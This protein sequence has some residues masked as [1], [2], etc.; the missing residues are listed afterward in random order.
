MIINRR[1]LECGTPISA[2]RSIRA[3]FCPGRSCL[4]KFNMRRWSSNNRDRVNEHGR[5]SS[6]RRRA[7]LAA[8]VVESFRH[9]EIFERD[10]WTCQLC[11][12][13]V[14]PRARHPDPRSASL[15]HVVPLARGGHH[16]RVN[17][18][19]AHLICN[20]RKADKLIGGLV[21]VVRSSEQLAERTQQSL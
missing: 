13:P 2:S 6:Q 8:T 21:T 15:D 17:V 19:L 20:L 16:T 10:G 4:Q 18:Q 1:C 5:A 14:D 12:E 3:R 7:R 9:P 11:Q